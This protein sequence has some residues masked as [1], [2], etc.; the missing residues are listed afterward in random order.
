MRRIVMSSVTVICVYFIGVAFNSYPLSQATAGQAEIQP[1]PTPTQMTGL[2]RQETSPKPTTKVE[3]TPEMVLKPPRAGNA[4]LAVKQSVL[5]NPWFWLMT[6]AF[7]IA[8]IAGIMAYQ[9]KRRE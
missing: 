7:S 2:Q 5:S 9:N 3:I 4:G 6:A 1:V 8:A